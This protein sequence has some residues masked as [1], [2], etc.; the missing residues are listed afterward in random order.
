[1]HEYIERAQAEN[2][3][4]TFGGKRYMILLEAIREEHAANAI[5]IPAT[6]IGDLSDG[7]GSVADMPDQSEGVR[8]RRRYDDNS[9]KDASRT[10][11]SPE[12]GSFGRH[13]RG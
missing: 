8:L 2:V 11:F 4:K 12:K 9:G 1:M 7:F 10:H 3:I 13:R 6:G 5:E